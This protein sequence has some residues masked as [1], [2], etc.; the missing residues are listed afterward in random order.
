MGDFRSKRLHPSHVQ[1]ANLSHGRG[2][3]SVKQAVKLHMPRVRLRTPG[4]DAR[5]QPDVLYMSVALLNR[6]TRNGRLY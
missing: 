1:E 3:L 4:C 2:K 6:R 5:T